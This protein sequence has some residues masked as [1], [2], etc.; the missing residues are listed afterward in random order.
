MEKI[1]SKFGN[2][3]PLE[4]LSEGGLYDVG[5]AKK[6]KSAAHMVGHTKEHQFGANLGWH[7][8]YSY[9]EPRY[10][11]LILFGLKNTSIVD[12]EFC[13]LK[14][15]Y[16]SF[17]EDDKE[18]LRTQ[19]FTHVDPSVNVLGKDIETAYKIV[20]PLVERH[21]VTN[22]EV[23][24]F[25][26]FGFLSEEKTKKAFTMITR[27]IPYYTS[28]VEWEDCKFHIM[29]DNY[30]YMHRTVRSMKWN[31][32]PRTMLRLQYDYSRINN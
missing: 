7:Q 22:E 3:M 21:P 30:K 1:A 8:D 32:D 28:V 12:T 25:S 16:D 23:L 18:Y 11:G 15:L 17:N 5:T 26:P 19:E 9:R 20:R 14:A 13:N 2:V 4:M 10:Y 31:D 6:L 27:K 24:N 29:V